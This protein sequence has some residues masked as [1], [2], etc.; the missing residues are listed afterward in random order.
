MDRRTFVVAVGILATPLAVRGQLG[1]KDYR[2][3]FLLTSPREV[4]LHLIAA[5]EAGLR[6]PYIRQQHAR[7]IP[8]AQRLS[9]TGSFGWTPSTGEIQSTDRALSTTKRPAT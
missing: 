7:S 4:Q 1:R 9:H 8:E 3:G 6:D 5:F 2:I